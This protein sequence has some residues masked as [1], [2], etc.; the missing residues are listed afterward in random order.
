LNNREIIQ[1]TTAVSP[2]A[3]KLTTENAP[4][5]LPAKQNKHTKFLIRNMQTQFS[6]ESLSW[7]VCQSLFQVIFR[8]AY[9]QNGEN[10]KKILR[11]R[12]NLLCIFMYPFSVED[13]ISKKTNK[14]TIKTFVYIRFVLDIIE[15][16]SIYTCTCTYFI[17]MSKHLIRKE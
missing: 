4:I 15:H 8:L 1:C 12:E 11:K 7:C 2:F 6:I 10:F 5:D 16:Y 14:I 9:F 17:Y 3:G 13:W